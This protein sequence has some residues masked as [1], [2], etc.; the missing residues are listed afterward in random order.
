VHPLILVRARRS[1]ILGD[2]FNLTLVFAIL[3]LPERV[4]KYSE[5]ARSPV[6][7][8]MFAAAVK[9]RYVYGN[10]PKYPTGSDNSRSTGEL[11]RCRSP[12]EKP[13]SK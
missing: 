13:D 7:T 12:E 9:R 8:A 5:L 4:A 3:F 6:V 2:F 11:G 1:E 10:N